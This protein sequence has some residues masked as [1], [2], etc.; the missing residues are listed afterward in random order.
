MLR[1]THRAAVN[2]GFRSARRNRPRNPNLPGYVGA[3]P[4]HEASKGGHADVV[5]LLIEQGADS[6]I[7]G[8]GGAFEGRV[9]QEVTYLCFDGETQIERER[10]KG[11]IERVHR[12]HRSDVNFRGAPLSCAS[13]GTHRLSQSSSVERQRWSRLSLQ[14]D[15][16]R[17]SATPPLPPPAP[18]TP[19]TSR[20]H[21]LL[22]RCPSRVSFCFSPGV[23]QRGGLGSVPA[24]LASC[25]RLSAS[26]QSRR[27]DIRQRFGGR[28]RCLRSF[29]S[30]RGSTAARPAA[31][32]ATL[33]VFVFH[34]D[35]RRGAHSCRQQR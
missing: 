14:S 31:N 19:R 35:T 32:A 26:L 6:R 28:H 22:Q 12:K 15:A 11:G 30:R 25:P 20:H 23:V 10:D 4:L 27:T 29:A 17:A 24:C 3:T 13:S 21:L 16:T 1:H 7:V 9:P 5:R 2:P 18:H 33:A 8:T 34:R